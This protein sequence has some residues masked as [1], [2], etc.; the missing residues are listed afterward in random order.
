VLAELQL[1]VACA[2][3]REVAIFGSQVCV[4]GQHGSLRVSFPEAAMPSATWKR[5]AMSKGIFNPNMT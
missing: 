4:P 5:C 3:L 2:N 1:T